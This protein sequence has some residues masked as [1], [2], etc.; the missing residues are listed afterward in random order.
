ME[1]VVALLLVSFGLAL[2]QDSNNCADISTYSDVTYNLTISKLCHYTT[3]KRCEP[4][5]KRLCINT[6][7]TECHIEAFTECHS[8]P[9]IDTYR[10]DKTK[11]ETFLP[12]KCKQSGVRVFEE[13]K[14]E[15]VCKTET[16]KVCDRVYD[17]DSV[18]G[19][20][21]EVLSEKNCHD[22]TYED[23]K[24]EPSIIKT[25]VPQYECFDDTPITYVLP[26]FMEFP[27]TTH[28]TK[29]EPKAASVCIT[30]Q[31]NSCD[32][33][34]WEECH[35]IVHPQCTDLLVAQPHQEYDQRKKCIGE[36]NNE[37]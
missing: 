16:K 10:N 6:P 19:R 35:E 33:V 37:D 1:Q 21:I 7:N 13:V 3:E 23:C 26:V 8:I 22:K 34:E 24:L 18:T 11:T 27:V 31:K 25:E 4:R 17:T 29:C 36:A 15:A 12:K 5:S 9:T 30:T 32:V 14:N 20:Q 2:G 28:Q